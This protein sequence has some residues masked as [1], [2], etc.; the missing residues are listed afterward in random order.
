MKSLVNLETIY[1]PLRVDTSLISVKKEI[2]IVGGVCEDCNNLQIDFLDPSTM[3]LRAKQLS[4]KPAL[5]DGFVSLSDPRDAEQILI[6][7]GRSNS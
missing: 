5:R 4:M 7:G 6:L 2:A 3:T 1:S